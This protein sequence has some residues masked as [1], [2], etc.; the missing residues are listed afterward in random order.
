MELATKK[1]L[2]LWTIHFE[3]H[4]SGTHSVLD[5]YAGKQNKTPPQQDRDFPL[6]FTRQSYV[7]KTLLLH[8]DKAIKDKVIKTTKLKT[9]P[10]TQHI[11]ST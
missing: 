1:A 8:K 3:K 9:K 5:S 6:Q 7:Y 10:N 11:R 4:F 2:I